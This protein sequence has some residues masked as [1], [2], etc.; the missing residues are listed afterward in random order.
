MTTRIGDQ[1]AAGI[2][3]LAL[4]ASPGG[5]F[6][7]LAQP[8]GAV[9]G[10]LEGLTKGPFVVYVEKIT[11]AWAPTDPEPVMNQK[12][13]TYVP[14]VLPIVAGSKVEFHSADPELHNV[15]AWATALKRVLFNIAI[16]P[17]APSYRKVFADPGVVRL[18]CNVH[19]EMLAFIVV[20]QNPHFTMVEKGATGFRLAGLPAGKHELRVWGEK[21]DDATLAKRFPVEVP[22]GGTA[23]VSITP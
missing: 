1:L 4:T 11:G 8:T 21:L 16:P 9:E 22:A 2:I 20:V 14:H 13:N 3:A 19:K 18:T 15:Y 6:P 12:H 17:S 10:T 23:R 5:A 7:A